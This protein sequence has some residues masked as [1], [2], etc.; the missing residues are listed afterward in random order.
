M[1]QEE[2]NGEISDADAIANMQ[3]LTLPELTAEQRL[4]LD[5][6]DVDIYE[7]KSEEMKLVKDFIADNISKGNRYAYPFMVLDTDYD[8]YLVTYAC[9]EEFRKPRD[10]DFMLVEG[11]TYR[12][13]IEEYN[14][15]K[16]DAFIADRT[17]ANF[18]ETNAFQKFQA[19]LLK[20]NDDKKELTEEDANKEIDELMAVDPLHRSHFS[21]NRPTFDEWKKRRMLYVES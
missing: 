18:E 19:Q 15:E 3:S 16:H 5:V 11:E 7:R 6:N 13:V 14:S 2:L 17:I 1:C 8:N 4:T 21:N 9:R 20:D 10:I 12:E